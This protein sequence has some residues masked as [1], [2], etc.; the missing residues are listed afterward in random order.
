MN[1]E[2][3]DTLPPEVKKVMDDMRREQAEWTGNYVDKHVAEALEWSRQKYGHQ[4]LQL[5]AADKAAISKHLNPMI[6]EY[7]K[8]VSAQGISGAQIIEDITKMRKKYEKKSRH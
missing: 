7:V 1:K 6:D 8:R 2:K 5:S 4:V 3:W